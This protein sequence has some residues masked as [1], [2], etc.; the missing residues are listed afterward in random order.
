VLVDG[1]PETLLRCN[2]LMRGVYLTPGAHAVEFVFRPQIKWLYVSLA[3]LGMAVLCAGVLVVSGRTRTTQSS[4]SRRNGALRG[5]NEPKPV[6]KPA[7]AKPV[8]TEPVR[9]GVKNRKAELSV[10]THGKEKSNGP[11]IGKR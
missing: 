8:E 10:K 3:A 11:V 6:T 1:K 2:Y 4:A 5:E 9:R 7:S